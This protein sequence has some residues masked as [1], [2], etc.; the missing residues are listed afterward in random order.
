MVDPRFFRISDPISL[1]EIVRLVGGSWHREPDANQQNGYIQHLIAVDHDKTDDLQLANACTFV[2]NRET[3]R[4]IK[5]ETNGLCL[6]DDTLALKVNIEDLPSGPVRCVSSARY[7]VVQI[8]NQLYTEYSTDANILGIDPSATIGKNC[9]IHPTA[10]IGPLASIGDD[11]VIGPHTLIGR[12][13][14]LGSH[15]EISANVTISHAD[16]G[17][18]IHIAPGV[19]IGQAGFG[20]TPAPDGTLVNIP[21]LGRVQIGNHVTIGANSTIDRGA[22]GDTVVGAHT[23]IDN[24][25]QIAHNVRI[26]S[27][28][29]IAAQTGISGSCVIGNGVQFGG[30]VGLADHLKIG[31]NAKLAARSG[32]M[33]S[34]PAGETWS[35]FPAKPIELHMR[36]V[37]LINRMV[38]ESMERKKK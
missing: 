1:E 2:T 6:I 23:H 24:L 28:C 12:G 35:G 4:H 31:D 11:A 16:L 9:Q 29:V 3:L 14:T 10:I 34:I 32:H 21:Q 18:D 33:R 8:A 20:V 17:E 26:G 13:V 19:R 7:A 30:N 15:C 38:R 37:A 36:E 22:F 27:N 25:V 5:T